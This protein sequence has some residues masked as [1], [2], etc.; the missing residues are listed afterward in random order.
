VVMKCL[1]DS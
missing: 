1:K